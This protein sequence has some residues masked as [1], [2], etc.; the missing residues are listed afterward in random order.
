MEEEEKEYENKSLI[1]LTQ[2]IQES[3]GSIVDARIRQLQLMHY[4]FQQNFQDLNNLLLILHDENKIINI[5]DIKNRELLDNYIKEIT[6][7]IFNFLAAAA[8]YVDHTRIHVQKHYKNTNIYL[9]YD[10]KKNK[11][12]ITNEL[13]SFI[14]DFRNY[15]LHF[16]V[17][18]SIFNCTFSTFE[19]FSAKIMISKDELYKFGSWHQ[20]SKAFIDKCEKEI[21]FE[22][23]CS[24]YFEIIQDFYAWYYKELEEYHKEEL[25]EYRNLRRQIYNRTIS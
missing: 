11:T 24:E 22:I 12:F 15:H 3:S 9:K 23:V 21:N 8:A 1:E 20:R 19:P 13:C 7:Q 10:V 5:M 18:F 2:K 25:E 4:I 17:P 16:A 14:K 6:R